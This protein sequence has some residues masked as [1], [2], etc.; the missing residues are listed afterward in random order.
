[1]SIDELS[2]VSQAIGAL[3]SS[4][5]SLET[6]GKLATK[7]TMR[8]L[9]KIEDCVIGNGKD[10]VLVKRDVDTCHERVDKIEPKLDEHEGLHNQ[11]KGAAKK[12]GVLYGG[13]SGAFFFLLNLLVRMFT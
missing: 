2:Q 9:E 12:A 7:T 8:K 6:A 3:Q 11:A 13:I 5:V 4:V 1:M 10:L